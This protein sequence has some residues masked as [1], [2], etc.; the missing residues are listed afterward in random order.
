M[1]H[2]TEPRIVQTYQ[3]QRIDRALLKAEA[4]TLLSHVGERRPRRLSRHRRFF[5]VMGQALIAVGER[6]AQ[7]EISPRLSLDDQIGS[8][9]GTCA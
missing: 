9:Q 6:L 7:Y 4:R 8:S 1:T 3:D 5:L 2:F